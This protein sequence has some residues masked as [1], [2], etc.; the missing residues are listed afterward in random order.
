MRVV[1]VLL[2]LALCLL[3][4]EV[5]HAQ[6]RDE[7]E[8]R[9]LFE[10]A[11]AALES[12]RFSV[13]RDLLRRSLDL[14]PNAASAF[15]LGVA[16]RGTGETRAAVQVFEELLGGERGEISD[17]QRREV[18]RLLRETRA[19]IAALHIHVEG[20]ETIEVRVDGERIGE[21]GDGETLTHQVDPGEHVVTAT[22]PR[23]QT[24]ERRVEL[25][26]GGS[27]R[28]SLAL[29]MSAD[30]RL[31]TLV[32][33]AVDPDDVLEIVGV[34]RGT[35]S[36]S[37][38]LEPGTYDVVVSGPAGRREST[39]DLE[40]GTTLRVRLEVDSGGVLA[41]PWLWTGVGLVV[42]GLVVGGLFL[43]VETEE[44]P[45]SDPVYG[46]ITTLSMP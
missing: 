23:R 9:R 7:R 27:R 10:E 25:E 37:R 3:A 40:A 12:G 14:A 8:A 38:D 17:G 21:A 6:S 35:G 46:V 1:S 32:V 5:G 42:A 15:N 16:L 20:A 22:A 33:E 31:G 43:F 28:L 24:E 39:V 34:A 45:V 30:A 41:S 36:L 44:A 4:T 29:Q 26:R 11:N 19:E 18:R 13:A 2:V